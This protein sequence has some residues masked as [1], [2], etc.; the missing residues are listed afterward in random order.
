VFA[1]DPVLMIWEVGANDAMRGTDID[2][3]AQ[4]L[5]DG[6]DSHKN[7]AIDIMFVDMKFSRS[8][9]T[10]INYQALHRVGDLY[11]SSCFRAMP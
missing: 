1:E 8:S 10:M 2:D 3:F 9:A 5:Q 6:V 11:D 4:T 7:S